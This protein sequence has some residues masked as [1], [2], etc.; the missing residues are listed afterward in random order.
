MR[1]QRLD[2][3]P[4]RE[5]LTA[6]DSARRG[7]AIT[8]GGDVTSQLVR[9]PCDGAESGHLNSVASQSESPLRDRRETVVT[10]TASDAWLAWRS[11]L[12]R[13]E[14]LRDVTL[15]GVR[16]DHDDPLGAGLGTFGNRQ[17]GPE[18]GAAGDARK[19]SLFART[20]P[21]G[22]DRVLV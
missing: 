14:G 8:G 4:G 13:E 22:G 6:T 19:Q 5:N 12:R 3:G 17:R 10:L 7:I 21:G 9:N 18:R 20:T 11:P 15:A 2:P 16:H 1:Q